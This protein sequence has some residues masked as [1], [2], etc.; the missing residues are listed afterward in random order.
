MHPLGRRYP[1][2]HKFQYNAGWHTILK[3]NKQGIFYATFP[4][5]ILLTYITFL[6][7]SCTFGNSLSN[8]ELLT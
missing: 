7:N 3:Q 2:E 4:N 6:Q 8:Q 1:I 5:S